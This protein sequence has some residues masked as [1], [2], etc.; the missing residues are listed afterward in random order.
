MPRFVILEHHWN[1]V[2]W[3]LML[4]VEG[5]LRTWALDAPI[6][7]KVDVPARALPDH[8]MDYLDYEG[9]VSGGRGT[10]RRWDRGEYEVLEWAPE[11]VRVKLMGAQLVGD[12]ELLRL[13]RDEDESPVEWVFR[14]GKV[15]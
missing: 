9:E 2:H 12:A 6:E 15:D 3:D 5:R 1:G 14:I 4:E 8:R 11:R 7:M 13:C 10:V